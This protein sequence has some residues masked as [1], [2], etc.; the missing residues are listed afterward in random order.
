MSGLGQNH[1]AFWVS[2]DVENYPLAPN[3]ALHCKEQHE[4]SQGDTDEI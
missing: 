4:D 2:I 3:L 1:L